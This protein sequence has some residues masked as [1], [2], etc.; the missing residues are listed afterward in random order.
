M[1]SI[2]CIATLI[3]CALL[4]E[5]TGAAQTPKVIVVSGPTVIAFFPPVTEKDL[6]HDPDTNESLSDFQL[7][8]QRVRGKLHDAGI[9]FQEIYASSFGVKCGGKTNTFH[10]Q[11][12]QVGYYFVAPGKSPHAEYGVMT[13]ADILR[14]AKEYFRPAPK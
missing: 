5:P 11:K 14:V 1:K 9:D 3:V 10:P 13:D 2:G 8:A 6:S 7:Y 12:M 4:C